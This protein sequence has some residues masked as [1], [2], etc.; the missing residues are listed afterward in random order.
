MRG[1]ADGRR[2]GLSAPLRQ[3]MGQPEGIRV[4]SCAA[5]ARNLGREGAHILRPLQPVVRPLFTPNVPPTYVVA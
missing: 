2:A 4:S 3:Q 5:Q 1:G